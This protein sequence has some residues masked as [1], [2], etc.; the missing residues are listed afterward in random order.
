MYVLQC[1]IGQTIRLKPS[2]PH[3]LNTYELKATEVRK[4][5]MAG[6]GL[7]TGKKHEG[8][9]W[10]AGNVSILN[11]IV[12]I[13]M[14]KVSCKITISILNATCYHTILPKIE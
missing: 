1:I 8:T 12:V 2:S 4:G 5:V 10:D 11:C 14:G 3:I 6:R 13:N 7:L 9:L